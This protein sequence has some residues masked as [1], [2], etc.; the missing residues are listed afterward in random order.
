VCVAAKQGPSAPF[1][2]PTGP[3]VLL[4]QMSCFVSYWYH[5]WA[6]LHPLL[7]YEQGKK[8]GEF[9]EEELK[10]E[11]AKNS[12]ERYMHY[13]QRW[14]ENDKARKQVH[15]QCTERQSA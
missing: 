12:L 4:D 6:L 2:V 13:Y 8:K 9:S 1:G 10:R 15:T 14:A 7:R 3:N 11:H 5:R